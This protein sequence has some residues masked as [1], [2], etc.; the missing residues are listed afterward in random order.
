MTE[1]P[2]DAAHSTAAD[3]TA[4]IDR[5][6]DLYEAEWR[7]GSPRPIAEHVAAA[8][9]DL[10]PALQAELET[11]AEELVRERDSAA[12]SAG[13]VAAAPHRL[14]PIIAGC[15]TFSC[16]P[17]ESIDAL[18][19]R[20]ERGTVV[21]GTRV[22]TQAA[23]CPGLQIVLRGRLVI[24]L[25]D[26]SG[27]RRH[28]DDV[29]PGGIVGEIGLLTGR[30]CT[31]HVTATEESE[32]LVL[33][34]ASFRELRGEFPELELALSQLVGDRLGEREFDG[35]CGKVVGPC[36][37]IRCLGR[38]GMGVVYEGRM[39]LGEA[40]VAV[41]MLRHGLAHDA[42]AIDRFRREAAMLD[43]LRHH[44]IVGVAD[45]FVECRTLFLIM[46]LCRGRD[47]RQLLAAH[48]P[49]EPGI[50][51]RLLGQ[52]A[53]ALAHAHA[54]GVVHRDIKPSNV[55][56]DLAGRAKLADFG[57]AA[58]VMEK[59]GTGLVGTPGYM[60]PEQLA[61]GELGPAA[62][63][64]AFGCL[65]AEVLSGRPLFDPTDLVAMATAK[66]ERTPSL[67]PAWSHADPELADIIAASLHPLPERRRL[68]LDAV[69][70]WA[71]PVPELAA[72]CG[73]GA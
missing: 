59:T 32:L 66:A 38:G 55:L 69:A 42:R 71:G 61:G 60:P 39:L 19:A 40:E 26:D 5:L 53:A 68:D 58:M 27:A 15:P 33:P 36:R 56:I 7:A 29:R 67:D 30:P 6:C 31:A 52:I 1:S 4:E 34:A 8:G 37:L 48:G 25:E 43:G 44:G 35:L 54:R 51:R 16:L 73:H 2:E 23:A 18:A 13:G 20:L 21:P 70:G 65:A 49:V 63:W 22:L 41:K 50:A 57:L 72:A 24:E 12:E 45:L 62:D 17:R 28:I 46:E 47:V 64:Y 9:A 14:V 3:R 11:V 10:R